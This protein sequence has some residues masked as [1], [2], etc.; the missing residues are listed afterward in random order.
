M[1]AKL[2]NFFVVEMEGWQKWA[3]LLLTKLPVFVVCGFCALLLLS[4]L[5]MGGI[6]ENLNLILGEENGGFK[7]TTSVE[8]V[9][10]SR[11]WEVIWRVAFV[12][13]ASV[14]K[15]GFRFI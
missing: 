5:V 1:S 4:V 9:N 14:S 10:L 7:E 8:L 12:H 3:Y 15:G 11:A 13:V 6:E 2:G